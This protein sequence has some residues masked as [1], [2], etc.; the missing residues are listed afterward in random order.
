[1]P[2]ILLVE[3]E[4]AVGRSIRDSLEDEGYHVEWCQSAESALLNLEQK[5]YDL[6]L[7]D[8]WLP[9]MDG[10]KLIE[11]V[12]R[13]EQH[14]PMIIMSGHG[15]IET[16]V[17][18]TKL[19]A[20]DFLEKPLSTDKLILTIQNCLKH[21]RLQEMVLNT[22]EELVGTSGLT[23]QILDL[24]KKVAGTDLP[25]LIT[26]ENGTGKNVL[27]H[28]IHRNS[29]RKQYPL[30]SVNC[31][32]I[33]ENLIESELFGFMKGAFTGAVGNKKGKFEL[34]H[35]GTL[36]LDEIG[37]MDLSTQAKIL[38]V[39]E[40]QTLERLGSET[41]VK[42][43]VR[44]IAATNRDIQDLIKKGLFRE[45]LFY[46]LNVLPIQMPTLRTRREDIP[47]LAEHFLKEICLRE[48]RLPMT[49]SKKVLELFSNY[50]WPGNVRELK[51]LVQRLAILTNGPEIGLEYLPLEIQNQGAKKVSNEKDFKSART[52]FEKEYIQERLE[53]NNFNVSKT[54][55]E[56]G[57][58][59]TALH[60]KIKQLG[61]DIAE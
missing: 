24:S 7:T 3:D 9:K 6:L 27:A 48:N 60:R 14:P 41:S 46:R 51:N 32:A 19:G 26:G 42:V 13:K 40:E 5:D 2:R 57:L 28:L 4:P 45:D 43:N 56:L 31:A 33:P 16:A 15:T 18:A 44:V 25:I 30:I 37:D 47:L 22:E 20:Y 34:A 58:D 17:K 35:E 53:T 38:K 12:S 61:I 55:Q 59:R 8:V 21:H 39:L 29:N 11:E 52:Q 36:F 49:F 10:L 54:A 1:M 23:K 50:P